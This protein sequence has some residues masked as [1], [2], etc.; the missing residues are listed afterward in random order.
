ME[1]LM[2]KCLYNN[3]ISKFCICLVTALVGGKSETDHTTFSSSLK[4]DEIMIHK[5]LP[6]WW[7]GQGR[8]Y[9]C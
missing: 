6:A 9:H 4:H 7:T 3:C 5:E 8:A 1:L 2:L